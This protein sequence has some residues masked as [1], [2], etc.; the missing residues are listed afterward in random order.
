MDIS[1][2]LAKLLGW[3]FL[4]MSIFVFCNVDSIKVML[5]EIKKQKSLQIFIALITL[6]MGLLLVLSHN[7]WLWSWPLVIT[8]ISWLI[9]ISG[10]VR[11]FAF[12]V[13]AKMGEKLLD[14]PL[15]F[16]VIMGIYGLIGLFLL[17]QGYYA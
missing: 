12:D 14:H 2:F 6:I 7:F 9:L 11:L 1:V 8:L 15:R 17:Y 10:L 16:K 4:I 5:S 3:Y 13:A